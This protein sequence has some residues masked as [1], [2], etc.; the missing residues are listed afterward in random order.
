MVHVRGTRYVAGQA[1]TETVLLTWLL[2]V[3]VCAAFQIYRVNNT[4]FRSLTA[5]H[6]M[7]FARA[8]QRNCAS[9]LPGCTYTTDQVDG[10]MGARVIWQPAVMPEVV[11]P[12]VGMFRPY[13]LRQGLRLS[14]NRIEYDDD[15]PDLPCKRTKMGSGAYINPWRGL[16]EVYGGLFSA[17]YYRDYIEHKMAYLRGFM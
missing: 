11:V 16:V 6:Q 5:A 4:I 14:S 2:I 9:D 1:T 3:V 8:F 7:V 15:C 13:G 12:V 17:D 10:D